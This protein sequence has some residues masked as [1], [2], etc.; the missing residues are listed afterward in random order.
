MR[1]HCSRLYSIQYPCKCKHPEGFIICLRA[2]VSSSH[3]VPTL[4]RRCGMLTMM[5][6]CVCCR[7]SLYSLQ[8]PKD[9]PKR[10]MPKFVPVEEA[11]AACTDKALPGS[12]EA[13]PAAPAAAPPSKPVQ[14]A[15]PAAE[16]LKVPKWSRMRVVVLVSCPVASCRLARLSCDELF[17]RL[18]CCRLRLYVCFAAQQHP[19]DARALLTERRNASQKEKAVEVRLCAPCACFRCALDT[20]CYM[21]TPA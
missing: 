7:Q 14:A 17:Q 3:S 10:L 4:L 16:A 13:A 9:S 1:W 2:C 15:A 6:G 20:L 12:A 5:L 19:G 21:T 11:Q 8:W 18:C